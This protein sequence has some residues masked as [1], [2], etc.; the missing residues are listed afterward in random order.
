MFASRYSIVF[1]P[2]SARGLDE[3]VFLGQ[4]NTGMVSPEPRHVIALSSAHEAVRLKLGPARVDALFRQPYDEEAR[5]PSHYADGGFIGWRKIKG[6]L[7]NVTV[8]QLPGI[9]FVRPSGYGLIGLDVTRG[10]M[11]A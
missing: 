6:D 8:L 9:Q 4:W 11:I 5:V 2:V 10:G 3:D 7:T 1:S